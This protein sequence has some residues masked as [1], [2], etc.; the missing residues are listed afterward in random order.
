MDNFIKNLNIRKKLLFLFVV[1]LF[2]VCVTS[3]TGI[4]SF[5][6][7]SG[8]ITT[9]YNEDYQARIYANQIM[10]SF[11]QIQKNVFMGILASDEGEMQEWI[12]SAKVSGENLTSQLGSLKEV[13]NGSYDLDDLTVKINS[14]VSIRTEI[15]NL[16]LDLKNDE[17]Y[18]LAK[19]KWIP[20]LNTVLTSLEEL[21]EDTKTS[22]DDMMKSINSQVVI[23]VISM[24]ILTII[25]I[26]AGLYICTKV[27]KIVREP[28]YEIKSAAE[29]LAQGNFELKLE[30]ESKDEFG[31]VVN[32]LKNIVSSQKNY[33]V[34]LLNVIVSLADKNLNIKP[35]IE[36]QGD[37][38]PLKDGLVQTIHD[39]NNTIGAL[40][41]SADQV[42]KGSDQLALTSQS[43]AEGATEQAGTVEELQA[44]INNITQQVEQ[45]TKS[46][47]DASRKAQQADNKAQDSSNKMDEMMQAMSRI[48]ETSKQIERI[49]QSIEG[50]AS[51]T[52]LLSLNAAIEAAR[53]GEAGRGFAVVAGEISEL[54]KQSAEAASNTRK[55]ISDSIT[56]VEFG[57]KVATSTAEALDDVRI[58]ISEIINVVDEVKEA[59]E[60]QSDA[61]NQINLGIEQISSVVQ[62]NASLAEEVSATSEELFAQAISLNN[63]VGEFTL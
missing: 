50:I 62:N 58:G 57:N 55:L 10:R 6:S 47:A 25:G 56:E 11:E 28:V 1:M 8:N 24:I 4:M 51:Q 48:S 26:L 53:A 38:I 35:A 2:L 40:Q 12:N 27:S 17:A 5:D 20:Q 22:G 45:N 23:L 52:N 36:Y 59:S 63:L 39:L 16:T 61:M 44:A 32:A 14:M 49:I 19:E 42:S 41:G 33:V 54:A 18:T 30:Y 13:Y 21:V 34:D 46:A 43:M 31:I 15:I 37:F 60:S 3:T 9:F 7:L 29:E